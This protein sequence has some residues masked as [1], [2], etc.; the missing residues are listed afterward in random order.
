MRPALRIATSLFLAAL[1]A[2][3]AML[4]VRSYWEVDKVWAQILPNFSV[5]VR[6][7]PG[8]LVLCGSRSAVR[9]P[10]GDGDWFSWPVDAYFAADIPR[11][12][13]PLL[14]QFGFYNDS[15]N[16]PLWLLV[17]C[18][19]SLNIVVYARRLWRRIAADKA[20]SR[21]AYSAETMPSSPA[22]TLLLRDHALTTAGPPALGAQSAPVMQAAS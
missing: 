14:G 22:G 13:N 4:W 7:T 20:K 9:L 12:S 21:P 6:V 11:P 1:C 8:Q 15:V 18:T 19:A 16:I 2:A 17:L 10:V 5:D 3:T